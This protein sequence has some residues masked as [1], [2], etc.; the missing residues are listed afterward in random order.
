MTLLTLLRKRTVRVAPRHLSYKI[1]AA[2][3]SRNYRAKLKTSIILV[4]SWTSK[5]EENVDG[6]RTWLENLKEVT[7]Y[8]REGHKLV[9]IV[10]KGKAYKR[11][12]RVL[13]FS[14]SDARLII[15]DLI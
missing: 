8:L 12:T 4:A 3:H 14:T 1:R 15:N 10:R 11:T 5:K 7:N 2:G 9:R 13:C 6:R